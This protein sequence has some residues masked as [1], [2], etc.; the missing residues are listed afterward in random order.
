M[1]GEVGAGLWTRAVNIERAEAGEAGLGWG[2]AVTSW[3]QNEWIGYS[4]GERGRRSLRPP[5]ELVCRG[6]TVL[7]WTAWC[8]HP[9]LTRSSLLCIDNVYL[10]FG[11]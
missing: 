4:K 8:F 10:F 6:L 3:R 5:C 1:T 11:P 2:P 7:V 9:L